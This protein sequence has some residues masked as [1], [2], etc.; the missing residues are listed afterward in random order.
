[1]T[2][3]GWTKRRTVIALVG[4]TVFALVLRLTGLGFMLPHMWE[5]DQ[6]VYTTQV[7]VLRSGDPAA[8]SNP[9][10]GWYPLLVSGI[11]SL[12]PA[13]EMNLE[14]ASLA[15]G[16]SDASAA[17]LQLRTVIAILSASIVPAVFL[18]A[19][20]FCE[21]GPAL[22]AA[23]LAASSVLHIWFAQQTRPHGVVSAMLA[24][25]L[26]AALAVRRRGDWKAY[27]FAGVAT[28]LAV[29]TLQSG[30]AGLIPLVV[31]HFLARPPLSRPRHVLLVG[32]LCV[33][34]IF[35]RVFYPYM[36]KT[37]GVD[38]SMDVALKDDRINLSGH[39]FYLSS[40]S[41]GGFRV[42]W[43]AFWSYDPVL[44]AL[45]LLGALAW[46]AR[47]WKAARG[48]SSPTGGLWLL[49]RHADLLVVS[50]FAVPYV[51]VFG[52][53][54]KT[55]VRFAL[56]LVTVAAC[57]GAYFCTE[58]GRR[59]WISPTVRSLARGVVIV[60]LLFHVTAGVRLAQ[61]R[62]AEDTATRA[63]DWIRDSALPRTVK[64][65]ISPSLDLPLLR[66]E[67]SL[68][69]SGYYGSGQTHPWLKHQLLL[70]SRPEPTY[71]MTTLAVLR[72]PER[73][74]IERD[75]REWA[76]N[77]DAQYVVFDVPGAGERNLLARARQ[78]L[79]GT[80]ELVARFSPLAIA[81]TDDVPLDFQD[82]LRADKSCL[83]WRVIVGASMGPVIEIYRLPGR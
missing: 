11:T 42:L 12:L 7:E 64:W 10:F 50:S 76:K 53:Y 55:F 75:P 37:P 23:L 81:T 44:L 19:R 33:A 68:A 46:I 79:Q 39:S 36:F 45:A 71:S 3:A 80:A 17:R 2:R 49:R 56:P 29:S 61:I 30:L 31:A 26:V 83:W 38:D 4:I 27:V 48:D 72:D 5:P 13:T 77:L 35:V 22:L 78:G 25:T 58:I 32:A 82:D 63:A 74:R 15:E 57:L 62:S 52:A 73:T 41:G 28:G 70:R 51:M 67:K 1:M 54:D 40:I 9:N 18:V 60:A 43:Q 14:P 24:W 34:A 8:E 21:R 69:E 65:G 66:D 16:L 59:S 6:R 47:T 20:R